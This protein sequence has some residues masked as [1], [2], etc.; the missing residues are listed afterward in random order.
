VKAPR[1]LVAMDPGSPDVGIGDYRHGVLVGAHHVEVPRPDDE[2]CPVCKVPCRHGI[3]PLL[4]MQ[5]CDQIE[6][7]LGIAGLPAGHP[8]L[9]EVV[10]CE[11]LQTFGDMPERGARAVLLG[12]AVMAALL[13]RA[14]AW[15]A[16]VFQYTPAVWKGSKR[17][18]LHQMQ[19]LCLFTEAERALL[20]RS[21]RAKY[22]VS[23]PLD[24]ASLGRWWLE[25]I[26]ARELPLRCPLPSS[27]EGLVEPPKKSKSG[28]ARPPSKWRHRR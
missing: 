14:L 12:C 17:K 1:R 2:R 27:F 15:G 24:G 3:E 20:P 16:R 13:D 22:F 10:I 11:Q 5:I 18:D 19:S 25:R 23:D 6:Q 8:D 28:K 26:G 4:V 9:P 21:P 7:V